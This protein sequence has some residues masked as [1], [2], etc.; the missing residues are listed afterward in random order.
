M[1]WLDLFAVQGALTESS[2]VSQFESID[3]LVLSLLYGSAL[4]STH[5][6][7]KNHGFDSMDLG[8]QSDV[9]AF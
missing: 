9:S 3:S 8:W 4:T 7:W 6:Y 2:P 5:G 1:D